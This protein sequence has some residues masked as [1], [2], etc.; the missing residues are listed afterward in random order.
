MN[1]FKKYWFY[2]GLFIIGV[3]FFVVDPDNFPR[4]IL[5]M[6]GGMGFIIFRILVDK[7]RE[8]KEVLPLESD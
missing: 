8:Q 2:I 7:K 3:G 1:L 4:R 6:F 5:F